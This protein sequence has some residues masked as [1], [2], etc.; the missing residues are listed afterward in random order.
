MRGSKK[1]ESG[2]GSMDLDG[3][4]VLIDVKVCTMWIEEEEEEDINKF[5]VFFF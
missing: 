4:I 2:E 3:Q 1:G 5:I